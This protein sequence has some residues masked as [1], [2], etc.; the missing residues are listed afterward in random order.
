M[1]SKVMQAGGDSL[2]MECKHVTEVSARITDTTSNDRGQ[3]NASAA[4]TTINLS[5]TQEVTILKQNNQTD[6]KV[7]NGEAYDRDNNLLNHTSHLTE[8]TA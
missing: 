8:N 5:V 4:T 6:D 1:T 7:E 2:N 3:I